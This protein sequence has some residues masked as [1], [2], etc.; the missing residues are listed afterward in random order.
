MAAFVDANVIAKAFLINPEQ[1][2]CLSVLRDEFVTDVVCL[3]EAKN[4]ISR[5]SG[6]R[7]YASDSI[8]SVIRSNCTVIPIDSI[9]LAS[10]IKSYARSTLGAFD[11][12][13]YTVALLKGC[14][15]II[16]YDKD[17]DNLA[18]KRIQP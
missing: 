17:F 6:S 8:R 3:L 2:L 5:I 1:E 14:S 4:V 9:I 15:E 12:V 7:E 18:I 13:H 10:C 11:S 16:S